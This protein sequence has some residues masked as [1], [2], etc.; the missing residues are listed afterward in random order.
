M[1]VVRHACAGSKA[2]WSGVDHERPLDPVGEAQA[3]ALVDVL[4][5]AP[6]SRLVAS[7][8]RRC[9]QTLEKL[10]D[11]RQLSIELDDRLSVETAVSDVVLMVTDPSFRDAVLST[12]GE[13][14]STL[15]DWLE[16]HGAE[17]AGSRGCLMD[18]GAAWRIAAADGRIVVDVHA[19]AP[20]IDCADHGASD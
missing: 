7:P 15:V 14:M 2:A 13:L 1:W 19:P 16:R 9:V 11:A 10:S 3:A 8:T 12:H 5:D 20:R 4:G 18:K 6:L 17:I